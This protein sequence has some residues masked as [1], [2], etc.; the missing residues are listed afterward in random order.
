MRGEGGRRTQINEPT[1]KELL[2]PPFVYLGDIINNS[3][4][5]LVVRF[6]CRKVSAVTLNKTNKFIITALNE[7]WA[8]KY[9]ERKRW[10]GERTNSGK[11][12]WIHCPKCNYNVGYGEV[13]NYCPNCGTRLD[14][15]EE[16]K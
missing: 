2:K 4:M 6:P 5:G 1:L 9:G 16:G 8:R 13:P 3:K 11:L 14:P 7:K 15:P 10:L 12:S